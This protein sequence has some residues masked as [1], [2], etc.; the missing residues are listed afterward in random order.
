MLDQRDAA[1]LLVV[2]DVLPLTSRKL[3]RLFPAPEYRVSVV[4]DAAQSLECIRSDAPDIVLVDAGP[5]ERSGLDLLE[6]IRRINASIMVIVVNGDSQAKTTIEAM[7]QGAY[8]CL[9]KP[10]DASLLKKIVGDALEAAR[11]RRQPCALGEQSAVTADALGMVGSS[12]AM[13]EV[14]KEIGRVADQDVPVLITGE[15]GAGKELV[16]RAIYEHGPR[17]Q[18]PF[19]AL[20][21]AAIPEQLLESELFGHEKG[22]FTGAEQRRIGK[23]EQCDGGTLFLDEIGDMPANLQAK[24]LRVIQDQ[25]FTR[26]GGN[27]TIRTDVRLVA[28]THRDLQT[29]SAEGKFRPD[30][31]YRLG[32]FTIHLPPLRERG[33]DLAVLVQHFLGRFNRELKRDVREVA[34]EAMQRLQ[35][36]DWPGNVRELQSVLKQ[37]LLRASGPV[38]L[39]VFLPQLGGATAADGS[40]SPGEV[41]DLA[42]FTGER[43]GPDCRDL[44]AEAHRELD[45]MLLCRV[46][47]Y[48]QGSQ[49]AA[50]RLLGIA[51][52]TLRVKMRDL[53]PA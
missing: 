27:E 6:Q 33:E 23:F 45:R 41:F 7:K 39:P 12:S 19:V 20:N 8:D 29:W 21:C 11:R 22:A 53:G 38:L 24:I 16:A 9:F 48:A 5:N 15:S 2:A 4:V 52:Q 14:Y 40:Q 1:H 34:P 44:Y 25:A 43:L 18:A 31:Y 10:V 13:R 50:A 42:S 36:Y 37:A 30:L 47:K 32:V 49:H 46:V 28:A 51:R 3:R 35:E 17:S 26:V